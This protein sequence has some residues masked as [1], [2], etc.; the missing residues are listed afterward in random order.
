MEFLKTALPS[1][2]NLYVLIG[3]GVALL[4][5]LSYFGYRWYT[6]TGSKSG[7]SDMG[8]ECNPQIENACGKDANCHPDETGEKG[9]CFPKQEEFVPEQPIPEQPT[10]ETQPE[11]VESE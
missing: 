8:E 6:N 10:E 5:V 4:L 2:M 7:F 1:W 3:L 11:N 9:I